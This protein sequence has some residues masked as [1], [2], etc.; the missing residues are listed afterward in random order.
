M[1]YRG[2]VLVSFATPL[3]I[4]GN[5][6]KEKQIRI[7]RYYNEVAISMTT[8]KELLELC[9]TKAHII[10]DSLKEDGVYLNGEILYSLKSIE[11][12]TNNTNI[13]STKH[14]GGKSMIN[15]A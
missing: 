6:A 5:M 14:L 3:I 1:L 10:I 4:G 13:S 8:D 9:P 11:N 15:E 12:N 7:Y 2:V